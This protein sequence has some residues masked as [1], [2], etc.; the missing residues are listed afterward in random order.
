MRELTHL[1]EEIREE[2]P[3]SVDALCEF[4]YICLTLLSE[5][6]DE[7]DDDEDDEEC[8]EGCTCGHYHDE[9]DEED[10]DDEDE[11]ED[12]ED[13]DEEEFEVSCPTCSATIWLVEGRT[14]PIEYCPACYQPYEIV[15]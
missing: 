11:E 7:D 8:H 1:L 15:G 10:D 9:D 12:D 3:E 13:E 2:H 6:H 5:Y 4:F 14:R